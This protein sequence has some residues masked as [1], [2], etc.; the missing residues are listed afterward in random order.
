MR[1]NALQR[2]LADAKAASQEGYKDTALKSSLTDATLASDRYQA[3]YLDARRNALRLEAVL[4]QIRSG[5]NGD[6]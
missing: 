4:E 6:E 2:E 1:I 5:K 3:E